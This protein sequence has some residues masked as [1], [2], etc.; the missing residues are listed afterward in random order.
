M[1]IARIVAIKTKRNRRKQNNVNKPEANTFKELHS[2][3]SSIPPRCGQCCVPW[4]KCNVESLSPAMFA[5]AVSN[6]CVLSSSESIVLQLYHV[7]KW[8]SA[9]QAYSSYCTYLILLLYASCFIPLRNPV[10]KNTSTGMRCVVHRHGICSR[11]GHSRMWA[12]HARWKLC[13]SI[14]SQ[15]M[16]IQSAHSANASYGFL[17][18][19]RKWLFNCDK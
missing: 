8:G 4:K 15:F 11:N 7:L 18:F 3:C 16:P 5:P 14:F 1:N 2:S 10:Y 9:T 13:T 19:S 6:L 17:I 12:T